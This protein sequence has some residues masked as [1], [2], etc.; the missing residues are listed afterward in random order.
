MLSATVVVFN[1][2]IML[3]LNVSDLLKC[4]LKAQNKPDS[5]AVKKLRNSL[6]ETVYH[7]LN[8]RIK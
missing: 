2:T 4:L 7:S 1:I 8:I 6:V 5:K 3:Q